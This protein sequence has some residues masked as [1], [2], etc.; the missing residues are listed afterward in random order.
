IGTGEA[1][2][3][4]VVVGVLW[5]FFY[6]MAALLARRVRLVSPEARV[7]PDFQRRLIEVEFEGIAQFRAGQ[8][9][10]AGVAMAIA[11]WKEGLL[12]R[13]TQSKT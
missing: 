7:D 6:V 13:I 12:W 3:T 2:S 5:S 11:L 4:G 1:A 9:I 10:R 8:A